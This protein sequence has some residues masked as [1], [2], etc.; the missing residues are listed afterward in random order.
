M[1]LLYF[2]YESASCLGGVAVLEGE[3]KGFLEVRKLLCKLGD[4][5][6]GICRPSGLEVTGSR[7]R[8]ESETSELVVIV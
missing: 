7:Q 3:D 4:G 5:R 8:P 6:S 2:G 1:A